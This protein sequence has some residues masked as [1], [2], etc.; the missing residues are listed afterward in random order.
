VSDEIIINQ[1]G[2]MRCCIAT[3]LEA[4]GVGQHLK[5]SY[6]GEPMAKDE[7][8]AWKWDPVEGRDEQNGSGEV[9]R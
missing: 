1:G 6:C 4:K 7:K 8:G 5:C 3:I 2:L 9:T